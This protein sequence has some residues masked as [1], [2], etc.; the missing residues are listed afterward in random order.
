[1][2]PSDIQEHGRNRCEAASGGVGA[3]KEGCELVASIHIPIDGIEGGDR[4]RF[5]PQR[6]PQA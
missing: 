5:I 2:G 1:M 3:V 6:Q 4:A